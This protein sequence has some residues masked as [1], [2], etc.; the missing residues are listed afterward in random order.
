MDYN[1]IKVNNTVYLTRGKVPFR[2]TEVVLGF[3]LSFTQIT[4][5]Q[6]L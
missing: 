1:H 6:I 4:Y 3:K 5:K 2:E